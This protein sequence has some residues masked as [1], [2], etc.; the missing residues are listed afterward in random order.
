MFSGVIENSTNSFRTLM[1]LM[2]MFKSQLKK[3]LSVVVH[4]K[5]EKIIYFRRNRIKPLKWKKFF[6]NFKLTIKITAGFWVTRFYK[7]FVF[8]ERIWQ[9]VTQLS[10]KKMCCSTQKWIVQELDKYKISLLKLHFSWKEC[11][12]LDKR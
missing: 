12:T 2:Q 7:F 11:V 8:F 4:W 10:W 3:T 6:L 1:L 9:L 5:E